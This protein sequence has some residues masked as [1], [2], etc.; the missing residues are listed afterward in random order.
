MQSKLNLYFQSR[1]FMGKI[2]IS[3]SAVKFH[4]Q[5]IALHS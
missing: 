2:H 3:V 4:K 5:D 1:I